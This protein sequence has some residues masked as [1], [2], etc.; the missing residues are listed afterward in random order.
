[1]LKVACPNCAKTIEVDENTLGEEHTC[2]VCGTAFPLASQ[3]EEANAPTDVTM[4][5]G[6]AFQERPPVDSD[7]DDDKAQDNRKTI[8]IV[9][10]IIIILVLLIFFFR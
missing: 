10:G 8:L 4:S 2:E 1:M 5:M 6:Q 7:D 3:P 9:I